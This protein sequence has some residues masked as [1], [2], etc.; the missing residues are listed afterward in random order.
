M[1]LLT[2]H[3]TKFKMFIKVEREEMEF[4]KLLSSRVDEL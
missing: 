4:G 1:R 3:L 2:L